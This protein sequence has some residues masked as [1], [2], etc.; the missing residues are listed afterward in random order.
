[1]ERTLDTLQDAGLATTGSYR[2][3]EE[4]AKP[5]MVESNGVK[6]G[7]VVGTFSLNGLKADNS[8]RVDMIDTRAM[9]EKAR[10]ARAAGADIVL[11]GTHDGAEYVSQP[12]A[13][14]EQSMKALAD[15]GEF[16]AIYG[17]HTHSVLPIEKYKDTWIVYGLG[18]SVA[19]HATDLAVN[20]EGLTVRF[21]FT[22]DAT[23]AWK[24]EAPA[25]TPHIMAREP[26]RWCALGTDAICT[27]ESEDAA[28]L[29]RTTETVNQLGAKE[30]GARLDNYQ[31]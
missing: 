31:S 20:R 25:W 30:D 1:V 11:A 8:W 27:T 17:H 28:S 6:V 3:V 21:R 9:I 13:T 16:D 15:S 23:G 4:A 26:D 19:R 24:T 5:L 7:I 22:K 14:Q 29:K 18:N 10:A 12:S 2:S